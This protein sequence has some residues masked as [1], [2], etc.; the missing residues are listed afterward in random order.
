MEISICG[1]QKRILSNLALS[2]KQRYRAFLE[3]YPTIEQ[4]VKNYH[5]A[6]YLGITTESLSRIRKGI[7]MK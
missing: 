7:E 4:I 5:I 2:A 1:F 6:S 3:T